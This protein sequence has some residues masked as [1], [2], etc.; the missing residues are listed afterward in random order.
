MNKYYLN[1]SQGQYI[2]KTNYINKVNSF[3]DKIKDILFKIEGHKEWLTIEN[4]HIKFNLQKVN[5]FT[6]Q[7]D[8]YNISGDGWRK[9]N[10]KIDKIIYIN[11]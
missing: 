2:I 4:K 10:H 7:D 8:R 5:S 9:V 11:K 6:V 3:Y 1:T